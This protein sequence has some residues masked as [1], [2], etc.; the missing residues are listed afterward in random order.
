MSGGTG[1]AVTR[2]FHDFYDPHTGNHF[3]GKYKP[4]GNSKDKSYQR[5]LFI[6]QVLTEDL[7]CC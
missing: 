1:T 6:Q 7:L 3:T 4:F 5:H 2:L